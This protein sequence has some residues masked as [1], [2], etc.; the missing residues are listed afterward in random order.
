MIGAPFLS[1]MV[2]KNGKGWDLRAR[3]GCSIFL[4]GGALVSCSTSTGAGG[5][6]GGGGGG[7]L[8]HPPPRSAPEGGDSPYKILFCTPRGG[9]L[10]KP[11]IRLNHDFLYP[12]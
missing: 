12:R 6:G 9:L 3:G 10:A 5:G 11:I 4:G 1:K 8:L 2:Y 7:R